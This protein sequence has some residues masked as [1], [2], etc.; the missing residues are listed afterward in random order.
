[1]QEKQN[2]AVFVD[3]DNIEIGVKS[4]LRREFDV[5]V[6]LD[7]QRLQSVVFGQGA[8]D[9]V[10][11]TVVIDEIEIEYGAAL[12]SALFSKAE[13]IRSKTN[14]TELGGPALASIK[15]TDELVGEQAGVP[16]PPSCLSCRRARPTAC[17]QTHPPAAEPRPARASASNYSIR[18]RRT[19]RFACR[20]YTAHRPL[21]E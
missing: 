18:T 5:A 12:R 11:H 8:A 4:T 17:H 6:A 2:I 10:A 1:M 21:R 15:V 13:T 19:F 20:R 7:A 16:V 9:G 14:A 3:Y